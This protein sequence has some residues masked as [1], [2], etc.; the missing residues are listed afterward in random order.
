MLRRKIAE[1]EICPEI[2]NYSLE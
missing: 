2:W 1:K